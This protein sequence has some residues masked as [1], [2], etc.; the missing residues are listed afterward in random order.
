MKQSTANLTGKHVGIYHRCCLNVTCSTSGIIY[1]LTFCCHWGS[2][3]CSFAAGLN[4]VEENT[5]STQFNRNNEFKITFF[6]FLHCQGF[7]IFDLW[8][9]KDFLPAALIETAL[10]FISSDYFWLLWMI[11][12]T[13]TEPSWSSSLLLWQQMTSWGFL[14]FYF[15]QNCHVTH[16]EY[17]NIG[18][19]TR[20]VSV[21]EL[22]GSRCWCWF[23]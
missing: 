7:W 20:P 8:T 3:V 2:L 12:W 4:W 15:N 21:Y 9:F 5:I 6:F 14:L 17:F 13:D 1:A 16:K 22:L 23:S 18:L 10:S 11:W 19:T